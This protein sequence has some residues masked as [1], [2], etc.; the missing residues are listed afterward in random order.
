MTPSGSTRR[1]TRVYEPSADEHGE[2]DALAP[3]PASLDGKVVG[4]LNNTKDLV[5]ILLDEV[6]NLLHAD[7][8][9]ARFRHFRKQSVSGAAPDLLEE[10]ATCDAVVTAVGD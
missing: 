8:P 1:T 2:Q 3:R 5:E 9:Q 4:L 6:E 10:L 7:Y